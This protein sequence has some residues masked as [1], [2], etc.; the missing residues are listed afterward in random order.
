MK[1]M[2]FGL[3]NFGISLATSLVEAGTEVIGI[4][5]DPSR[6]DLIK[7]QVTY[8]VALDATNEA[9]VNTLPYKEMDV[10]VVAIGEHEGAAILTTAILK[11]NGAKRIISRSLSPLHQMVLEAMG[12]EEI[13]H[14]EQ[15]SADRLSKMIQLKWVLNNFEVDDKY[16]ITEIQLG[17]K[18]IGKQIQEVDFR[19]NHQL[20]II[21][22]IREYSKRNILGGKR[23]VRESIGVISPETILESGDILVVFGSNT[24]IS[25]FCERN[26]K[27]KS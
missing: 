3:G 7:D 1:V 8:A 4:D 24:A 12:I 18:F 14:P 15:E 5:L 6:V 19:K 21:T 17:D 23:T 16:S 22:I 20:N 13:V 10:V 26:A 11:K 2:I 27:T 9:A 25:T